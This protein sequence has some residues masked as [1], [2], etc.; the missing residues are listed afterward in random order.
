MSNFTI[1]FGFNDAMPDAAV[2]R[3]YGTSIDAE[4]A[5]GVYYINTISGYQ[6]MSIFLLNPTNTGASYTVTRERYNGETF[7]DTAYLGRGTAP[8]NNI[9]LLTTYVFLYDS[10]GGI[11]SPFAVGLDVISVSSYLD[12]GQSNTV[13]LEAVDE[14]FSR[15]AT[16]YMDVDA[17]TTG[18]TANTTI[19]TA[20]W[21]NIQNVP[22][23]MYPASYQVRISAYVASG[24]LNEVSYVPY[25][26]KQYQ[27]S[28]MDFI[29]YMREAEQD[30]AIV[31]ERVFMALDLG[32]NEGER[33][34][35]DS[36]YK[37]R[38]GIDGDITN[39]TEAGT[40]G[41]VDVHVHIPPTTNDNYNPDTS[42]L[43]PQAPGQAMSVDNLLY[44]S[45][46]LDDSA[47]IAFGQYIWANNLVTTLY[48]TQTAP[49]E[50]ILSCK[51][52]PFT[53]GGS[54]TSIKIGNIDTQI[55]SSTLSGHV[56]KTAAGHVYECGTIKGPE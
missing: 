17:Y 41:T 11:H 48:A 34:I 4:K 31:N 51:R 25:T 30:D 2:R 13:I 44:T 27:T 12:F 3:I 49:I 5:V 1:D 56:K 54:D 35:V 9:W 53:V 50:N 43:T 26:A 24:H 37:F 28:F 42:N 6:Y 39:E 19:L 14:Y 52:I 16:P 7:S 36:S 18:N 23:G 46:V 47:I 33:F 40:G 15:P 29:G 21:D 20:L 22:A 55:G 10:S 8:Y 32:H 38:L 45:Y